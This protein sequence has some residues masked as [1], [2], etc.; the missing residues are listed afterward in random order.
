M[1]N[2]QELLEAADDRLVLRSST[3]CVRLCKLY[4]RV[5]FALVANFFVCLCVTAASKPSRSAKGQSGSSGSKA[6]KYGGKVKRRNSLNDFIVGDSDSEDGSE[7][8]SCD[9]EEDIS[10]RL[11]VDHDKSRQRC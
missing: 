8:S 1:H 4:I 5:T 6:G 9:E 10:G 2:R 7:G 3:H 11:G